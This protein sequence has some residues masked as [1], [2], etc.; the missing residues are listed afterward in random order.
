MTDYKIG[1]ITGSGRTKALAREMAENIA[2]R[3]AESV[4][5]GP[6]MYPTPS[7]PPE[8]WKESERWVG[9][10]VFPDMEG[11]WTLF[12][13]TL[14]GLRSISVGG[15]TREES[16]YRIVLHAAQLAVNKD[17]TKKDLDAIQEWMADALKDP[18]QA[19]VERTSLEQQI[20]AYK[21]H[22]AVLAAGGSENEAHKA[23]CEQ[24]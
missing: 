7:F 11:V 13:L 8:T 23:M 6:W 19:A 15:R 22:A 18:S 17:T 24:K 14:S 12:A 9:I 5:R 16:C 2:S 3:C 21:T 10:G 20:R 4:D 1:P